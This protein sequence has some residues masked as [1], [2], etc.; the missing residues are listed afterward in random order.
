M[1]LPQL[2]TT[3]MVPVV[4]ALLLSTLE[5]Q[6]MPTA[7]SSVVPEVKAH[8]PRAVETRAYFAISVINLYQ[9]VK[10]YLT[11]ANAYVSSRTC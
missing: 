2:K 11:T 3:L 6:A 8:L 1:H 5:T 4:T 10:E 9:A 7:V